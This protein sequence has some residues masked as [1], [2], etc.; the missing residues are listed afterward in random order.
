M[1][2][3][4]IVDQYNLQV[5]AVYNNRQWTYV[6]PMLIKANGSPVSGTSGHPIDA[7]MNMARAAS[8]RPLTVKSLNL[9]LN[10]IQY[11]GW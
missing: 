4:E 8:G 10:P 6:C 5:T 11:S 3:S 7:L 9:Q 1:K 2:L